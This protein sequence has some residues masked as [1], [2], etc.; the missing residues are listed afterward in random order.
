L[1]RI[2]EEIDK[3]KQQILINLVANSVRFTHEGGI[4]LIGGVKREEEHPRK[5]QK[6]SPN[7]FYD[8][9]SLSFYS[10]VDTLGNGRSSENMRS[11][12]SDQREDIELVFAI[13]DT[14]IGMTKVSR[15]CLELSTYANHSDP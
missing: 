3:K 1:T 14:G 15:L 12:F 11:Y 10:S 6:T 9:S 5:K 7:S 8:S 13:E 4:K 2:I